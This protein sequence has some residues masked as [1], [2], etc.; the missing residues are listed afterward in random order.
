MLDEY[1]LDDLLESIEVDVDYKELA[2]LEQDE[3]QNK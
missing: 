1:I 3:N 2:Q